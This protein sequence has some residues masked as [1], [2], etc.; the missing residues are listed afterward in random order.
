MAWVTRGLPIV[1][2]VAPASRT[3]PGLMETLRT[4]PVMSAFSMTIGRLPLAVIPMPSISRGIRPTNPQVSP[5]ARIATMTARRIHDRPLTTTIAWSRS[6]DEE[7][8][9][10][11]SA[12]V[13]A[14]IF[15]CDI[16]GPS[17]WGWNE[18]FWDQEFTPFKSSLEDR[19]G[20]WNASA[21]IIIKRERG[22]WQRLLPLKA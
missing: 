4:A 3:S 9:A 16:V 7:R 11:A 21:P 22:W 15:R 13:I 18:Q 1:A 20:P 17:H 19:L 5:A 6:S 14:W 2:I 10:W 8:W 12:L